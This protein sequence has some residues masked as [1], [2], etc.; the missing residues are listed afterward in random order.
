MICLFKLSNIIDLIYLSTLWRFSYLSSELWP[1]SVTYTIVPLDGAVGFIFFDSREIR[2][3]ILK[4]I[5]SEQ[6]VKLLL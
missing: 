5:K 2:K 3:I 6:D 4:L 1:F